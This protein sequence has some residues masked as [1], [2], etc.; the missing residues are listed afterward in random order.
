MS[1]SRKEWNLHAEWLVD[2]IGHI[3]WFISIYTSWLHPELLSFIMW[4]SKNCSRCGLNISDNCVLQYWDIHILR[5]FTQHFGH[6][7]SFWNQNQQFERDNLAKC[8]QS[9]QELFN[10]P[11]RIS[12]FS[13]TYPLKGRDHNEPI[14]CVGLLRHTCK[15]S[16]TLYPKT[17]RSAWIN[18]SLWLQ[19][20][21]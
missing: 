13:L 14:S 1:N 8:F 5:F 10:S 12:S 21:V 2:M 3:L 15:C 18:L 16:V 7:S 17:I 20:M 11:N 19:E 9:P 4:L 6:R